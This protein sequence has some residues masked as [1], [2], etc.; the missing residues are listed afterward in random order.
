MLIKKVH[1]KTDIQYFDTY[2]KELSI[3]LKISIDEY[4]YNIKEEIY[5]EYA[6]L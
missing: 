1:F 4:I 6:D 5:D 3:C 2:S